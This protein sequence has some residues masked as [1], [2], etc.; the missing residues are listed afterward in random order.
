[1]SRKFVILVVD[2]NINNRVT[3]QALLSRLD[4]CEVLE[5]GSG[6]EALLIT[7]EREVNLILLD[8]QMPGMDGF[9]TAGHLQMTER[10]RGIPIVFVTAIFKADE[11]IGRG[12]GL[13]AVDYLMKPLDD[14]L[15][16]NRV[17]L[18]QKL[19][20][21]ET[22][23]EARSQALQQANVQLTEARDA[24]EAANRAK[25]EFLAVMSHEIRTPLNGVIGMTD[26]LQRTRLD[27]RQRHY[28]SVV[29][30]SGEDLLAIISDILDFS[31]IEAG[32][33]ELDRQP[34][35][36]NLLVEEIVERL[37]PVAYGKGLELM[38]ALPLMPV[39]VVGDGKRLGQ[40]L[41]NLVGNAIKFTE[42]GHVLA[43]VDRAG[44]SDAGV[45]CR[46]SV[47][48]TGIGIAPDQQKR[49]F[50]PF[51]Q[52]DSSTTRRFGG[53]GLGLVISQRLVGMMG[54][55]IELESEPGS[56][57]EFHFTLTLPRALDSQL[58][59]PAE[60][61][62]RMRVLVLDDNVTNLEILEQQLASWH[63]RVAAFHRP[64]EALD[65][66]TAGNEVDLIIS[67]MMMPE[68]DGLMFLG[69]ARERLGE[70]APPAIILSSAADDFQKLT[71]AS[72]LA[73]Q[74]LTKPVRRSD[75]YNA[76]L[77]LGSAAA[78]VEPAP[79]GHDQPRLAG[80]VLLVEDNLVNQELATAMLRNL[81]CEVE[82]ARNGEEA[83][84]LC[85]AGGFDL[86]L[87][88]CEMPVMD[89]WQA[90]GAI[91]ARERPGGA[92]LTI[93]A[94]TANAGLGERERCLQAGMD[95]YLSKPFT[96]NE[97][98]AVL[99]RWLS[100]G[101]EAEASAEPA[102]IAARDDGEWVDAG[103]LG[104]IRAIQQDL[105]PRMLAAWMSEGPMLLAGIR[106]AIDA[107]DGPALF[108]AAHALK[109]CAGSVGAQPLASLCMELERLGKGEDL[110]GAANLL[111]ELDQAFG[112]SMAAL[113]A[114]D[115]GRGL[116]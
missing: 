99:S 68:M 9:E 88:D 32:K 66:L 84:R 48:D 24:A 5:A 43:K 102:G 17:R 74:V 98:G 105:L 35:C 81:G 78:K 26:L 71:G 113:K 54:G 18:Y 11:F 38:C 80:R 34:F 116:A 64:R 57:S 77:Q 49:L 85:E 7:L 109:N 72:R 115:E 4:D 29:H 39:E 1:M 95:D 83:L 55:R 97:L 45:T 2:D 101:E 106:E 16:L 3:L 111:P 76:L 75:L 59:P 91:R 56:G 12:Y 47:K 14:N 92:R 41:T 21:R 22:A 104:A 93:V 60:D 40:V 23:L 96:Q 89:G 30:R 31:K 108:R 63:C 58:C 73:R 15:L 112:C 36:L 79:D 82:L 51:S 8:V 27:D 100:P 107:V 69:E 46:I 19:H 25:S 103:A 70:A 44:E 62:A 50:K 87:M 37:A 67:D 6:E 10:T 110:A 33:F 53:T 61:V 52:A 90:T 86:A 42:S 114:V 65:W 20:E 13:G 94:L 28:V